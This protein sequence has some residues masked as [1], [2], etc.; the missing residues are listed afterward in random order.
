MV[1][2]S[3]HKQYCL[4]NLGQY[5]HTGRYTGRIRP[6]QPVYSTSTRC[7]LGNHYRCHFRYVLGTWVEIFYRQPS[8][9]CSSA[10]RHDQHHWRAFTWWIISVGPH[11][12]RLCPLRRYLHPETS[13]RTVM[14][15][16]H[17]GYSDWY[18]S[19]RCWRTLANGY[20]CRRIWRMAYRGHRRD[21]L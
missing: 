12:Y 1:K 19:G 20:F 10:K 15:C 16:A 11:N 17:T 5:N 21:K 8:S 13:S 9:R 7:H 6:A 14:D 18:I 3:G 4:S 2:R